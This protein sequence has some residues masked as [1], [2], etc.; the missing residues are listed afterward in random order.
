MRR[1]FFFLTFFFF[2]SLSPSLADG[3]QP[4]P[5]TRPSNVLSP[6]R[7]LPPPAKAESRSLPL[8]RKEQASKEQAEIVDFSQSAG[9]I[10]WDRPY[11]LLGYFFAWLI[12]SS[13][14]FFFVRR[15]RRTDDEL[16]SL[17]KRLERL[18]ADEDD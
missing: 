4:Q 18:E 7:V 8:P 6:P 2:A 11:L 16:T 9:N 5:A 17:E 3:L 10:A 13:Y 15:M 14:L 1:F 12:I